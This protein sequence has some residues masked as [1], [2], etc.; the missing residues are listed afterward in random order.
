MTRTPSVGRRLR[1]LQPLDLIPWQST[2]AEETSLCILQLTGHFNKPTINQ[3]DNYLIFIRGSKLLQQRTIM[4][5][6][7]R[8]RRIVVVPRGP[9]HGFKNNAQLMRLF[10]KMRLKKI[11]EVDLKIHPKITSFNVPF[12]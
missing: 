5:S 12:G 3:R 2:S 8:S 10:Q 9:T 1:R 11:N 7:H 6:S 4:I